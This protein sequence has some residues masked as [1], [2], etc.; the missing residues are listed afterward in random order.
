MLG[1]LTLDTDN[2]G[3]A[4]FHGLLL[5]TGTKGTFYIQ[6]FTVS[7]LTVTSLLP[8]PKSEAD[9]SS[10]DTFMPLTEE[11]ASMIYG[12][13]DVNKFVKNTNNFASIVDKFENYDQMGDDI[14]NDITQNQNRISKVCQLDNAVSLIIDTKIQKIDVEFPKE[15]QFKTMKDVENDDY[16]VVMSPFLSHRLTF[17]VLDKKD[18]VIVNYPLVVNMIILQFPSYLISLY[19]SLDSDRDKLA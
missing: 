19:N 17:K 16:L 4:N 12:K 11:M 8:P 3:M 13:V 1:T 18:E 7:Q 14:I 10:S 9:L 15:N 6:A 2:M 5:R